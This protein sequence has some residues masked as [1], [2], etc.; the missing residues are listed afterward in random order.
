VAIIYDLNGLQSAQCIVV[1]CDVDA[2]RVSIDGIPYQFGNYQDWFSNL[3][4]ALK[5][6]VLDLN[7]E[8]PGR[9]G[10]HTVTRLLQ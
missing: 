5:V 6:I 2:I 10:A 8:R 3:S 7:L 4:D 1:E 9:H